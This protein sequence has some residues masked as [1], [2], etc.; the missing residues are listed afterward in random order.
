MV[1]GSRFKLFH[2]QFQASGFRVGRQHYGADGLSDLHNFTRILDASLASQIGNVDQ[3]VNTL[4]DFDK[5][6][7]LR[8]SCYLALDYFAGWITILNRIP[9][10]SQRL[11][12]PEAKTF[13]RK[14][15]L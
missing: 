11:L 7:E 5:R 8:K 4:L 10:I 12:Q 9:R 6:A 1:R 15:Q 14:V 3:G 2:A 13:R